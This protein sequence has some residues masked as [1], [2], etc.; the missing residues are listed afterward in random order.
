VEHGGNIQ[1]QQGA[2]VGRRL[3]DGVDAHDAAGSDPVLNHHRLLEP[4]PAAVSASARPSVSMPPPAAIGTTSVIGRLEVA[5]PPATCASAGSDAN[6]RGRHDGHHQALSG[7]HVVLRVG[8]SNSAASY[9][10]RSPRPE[11]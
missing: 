3:G 9:D 1:E 11:R 7:A 5:S 8:C 10:D 4:T 6:D 2:A